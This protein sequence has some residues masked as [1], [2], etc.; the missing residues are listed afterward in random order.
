MSGYID[1]NGQQWEH[2]TVCGALIKLGK[3][4]CKDHE[5]PQHVRARCV[6]VSHE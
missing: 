3:E 4:R 2:C 1:I 6:E 5:Q